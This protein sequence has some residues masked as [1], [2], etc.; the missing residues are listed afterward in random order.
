MF[1]KHKF[2]NKQRELSV[3]NKFW[4]GFILYT[5]GYI[6]SVIINL[7]PFIRVTFQS[8]G[9]LIIILNA[10][11]L[12]HFNFDNIYLKI[13]AIIYYLWLSSVVIRGFLLEKEFIKIMIFDPFEGLFVYFVPL[14]VIFSKNIYYYKKMFET[15]SALCVSFIIFCLFFF[16]TLINRDISDLSAQAALEYSSKSLSISSG[17]LLLT[18]IYH[19]NKRKFLAFFAIA[20]TL[21]FSIIKARR[22]LVFM[23]GFP[24][25]MLVIFHFLNYRKGYS[26]RLSLILIIIILFVTTYFYIGTIQPANYG[27]FSSIVDRTDEDT[28]SEVVSIFMMI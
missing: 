26:N 6:L 11:N 25:I 12:I 4:I 24:L 23:A 14:I 9:L 10:I 17:F 22:G 1:S 20:L 19:S 3:I 7:N 13:T 2:N 8:F 27:V 16:T 5:L 28:R 18:Y 21:M 15:I